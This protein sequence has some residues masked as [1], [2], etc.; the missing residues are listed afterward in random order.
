MDDVL[1]VVLIGVLFLVMWGL[2]RF[3]EHLSERGRS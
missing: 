1:M 3:C 2:S